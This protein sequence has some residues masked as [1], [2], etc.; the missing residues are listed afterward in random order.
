MGVTGKTTSKL[1]KVRTY[2]PQNLYQVGVNGVTDITIDDEGLS[3]IIYELDGITY[4]TSSVNLGKIGDDDESPKV[5]LI[6][7]LT[8]GISTVKVV[9][10]TIPG[11]NSN[12]ISDKNKTIDTTYVTNGFS[13]DNFTENKITKREELVG[14]IDKPITS[15]DLFIERD[16]FTIFERHQRLSEINNLASL[17]NY[18]NG[19]Y[20]I[21]NTI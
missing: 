18:R 12:N 19:Y 17:I 13:F 7:P 8:F 15:S 10:A 16:E 14:L 3:T 4:K 11:N 9:D 6:D 5:T 1:F 21:I 2:N 20:E